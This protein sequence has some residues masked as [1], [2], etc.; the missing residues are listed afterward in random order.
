MQVWCA[1]KLASRGVGGTV[2]N[3]GVSVTNVAEVVNILGTKE[4]N[5]G[6]RVNGSITPLK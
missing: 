2:L 1:R 4:G 6:E 5:G 3:C